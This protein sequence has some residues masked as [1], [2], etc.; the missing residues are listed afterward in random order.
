M[1]EL[2]GGAHSEALS[3]RPLEEREEVGP[4][5]DRSVAGNP[6]ELTPATNSLQFRPP[7]AGKSVNN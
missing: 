1:G 4:V 2:L 3:A 7:L 5:A 6:E